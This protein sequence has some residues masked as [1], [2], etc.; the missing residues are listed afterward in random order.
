MVRSSTLDETCIYGEEENLSIV[1]DI[2]I[3]LG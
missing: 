3:F 2:Y 1:Q